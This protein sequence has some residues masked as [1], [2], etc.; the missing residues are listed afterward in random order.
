MTIFILKTE[1]MEAR[2]GEQGKSADI[3]KSQHKS[4]SA[5]G[6]LGRPMRTIL[7]SHT[8]LRTIGPLVT[9]QHAGIGRHRAAHHSSAR[10]RHRQRRQ[11]PERYSCAHRPITSW[12]G[13]VVRPGLGHYLAYPKGCFR[14]GG[15]Y[16]DRRT[17]SSVHTA[18]WAERHVMPNRKMPKIRSAIRQ[19]SRHQCR[20]IGIAWA[21]LRLLPLYRF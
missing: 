12:S 11:E 15:R 7:E 18:W 20:K 3:S 16:C 14:G 21:V 19:D 5:A 1:L 9:A 17:I 4:A 6:P 2:F 13:K 8:E 10:K